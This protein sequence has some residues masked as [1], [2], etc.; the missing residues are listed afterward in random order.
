MTLEKSSNQNSILNSTSSFFDVPNGEVIATDQSPSIFSSLSEEN[1]KNALYLASTINTDNYN[2]VLQFGVEAQHNLKHFTNNLLIQV[3]RNDTSP[4]REVLF[5]LMEQLEKIDPDALVENN[6]GFFS[7]LFNRSKT[8][9]QEQISH[10]KRLSVQID[11]LSI[12]LLHAQKGLLSDINMLEEL[13]RLNEEY[14][15]NINVYIAAGQLKKQDMMSNQL[16]KLQNE[17]IEQNDMISKQKL[18]DFLQA[19]EWLDKRIYDLQISREIAIQSAPQ[20]R[21]IQQTNRMLVEKI[22]SSVLTTIPLWQTQISMLVNINNQRRINMAGQ[23]L[24]DV[25]DDMI[26]KNAKMIETTARDSK[27]HK[28]ISHADIDNFKQTQLQL[29]ESI[30][31]TLRVQAESNVQHAEIEAKMESLSK[32]K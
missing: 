10:Y 24:M 29:I 17:A 26:R 31:E 5:R 21:L 20:I 28:S 12:Q 3:Q 1:Q 4:I 14:Y 25:S 15:H 2:A 11:R 16:P 6:K 18:N 32:N 23:R 27:R 9:I 19:I 8:T 22:Q 30:E 7:K 13:Y